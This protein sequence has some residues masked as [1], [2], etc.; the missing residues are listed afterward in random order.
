MAEWT[1]SAMPLR[2]KVALVTG[3][4]FVTHDRPFWTSDLD[5]ALRV[6]TGGVDTHL[7]AL[8]TLLPLLVTCGTGVV[9]E[10]TDGDT[11]AYHG[12]ALPYYLVKSAPRRIGTAMASQL[13]PYGVTAL[14][15]TPGFL[16]SEAMLAGFGVT[17]ENWRDGVAKDPNYAISETPHYLGRAI[18]ALACDPEVAR[19]AGQS[20]ASWTLMGEYG[21][22]DLDGSQPDWGRWFDEVLLAGRDPRTVAPNAYR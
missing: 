9:V 1:P 21:F 14:T 7:I 11:D 22:T 5:T 8:H 13:R 18:A 10:V 3:D 2:G 12:T 15:V 4:P 17:E 6:H 20:L 19:F 16:R